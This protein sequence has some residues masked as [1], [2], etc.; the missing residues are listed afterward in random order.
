MP[1]LYFHNPT[2]KTFTRVPAVAVFVVDLVVGL[3]ANQYDTSITEFP[4]ELRM[5]AGD[6]TLR[7]LNATG[8]GP[9]GTELG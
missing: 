4:K 5:I 8:M 6:A 9:Y 3:F 2:T 1:N 7:S